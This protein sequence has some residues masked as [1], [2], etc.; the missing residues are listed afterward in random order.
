M[1]EDEFERQRRQLVAVVAAE[2]PG[3]GGVD[4]VQELIVIGGTK[5]VEHAAQ[6][7]VQ[8]ELTIQRTQR[9]GVG[10]LFQYRFRRGAG[11]PKT[12]DQSTDGSYFDVASGVEG[13]PIPVVKGK[14]TDL[15]LPAN[16]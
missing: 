2:Q 14:A 9:R 12:G 4:G 3:G 10:N 15:L 5:A 6:H 16:L 11:A 1:G 8:A 7:V 13:E